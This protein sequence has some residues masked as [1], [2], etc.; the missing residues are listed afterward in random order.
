MGISFDDHENETLDRLDGEEESENKEF[1]Q[2]VL[3]NAKIVSARLAAAR[4]IV[5][6][7]FAFV[8]D[9]DGIIDDNARNGMICIVYQLLVEEEGRDNSIEE[10][11]QMDDDEFIS[12]F[13][14]GC[15]NV[16]APDDE[17]AEDETT[18]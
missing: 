11:E 14:G 5:D 1:R 9:G 17:G 15:C 4:A 10:A 6:D 7:E 2:F 13:S 3:D 18:G 12:R 8:E 16:V